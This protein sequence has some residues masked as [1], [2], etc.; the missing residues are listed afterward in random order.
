[1]LV[2]RSTI[3]LRTDHSAP[4]FLEG[5]RTAGSRTSDDGDVS[6]QDDGSGRD[7][8]NRTVRAGMS[9]VRAGCTEGRTTRKRETE[10][11][12]KREERQRTREGSAREFAGRLKHGSVVSRPPHPKLDSSSSNESAVSVGSLSG[13][14]D[15]SGVQRARRGK[16][17]ALAPGESADGGT[18]CTRYSVL[19]RS[20]IHNRSTTRRKG[21]ISR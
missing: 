2:H 6:Q 21:L 5:R 13:T 3:H 17:D 19:S 10:G 16:C 12:R 4:S 15:G 11:E 9:R 7:V 18:R 1:M 8:L 20:T 14:G